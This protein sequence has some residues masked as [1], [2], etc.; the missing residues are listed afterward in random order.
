[1]IF[2][3]DNTTAPQL[4]AAL[5][6]VAD[7]LQAAGVEVEVNKVHV[8]S[9]E[10]ARVCACDLADDPRQRSGHRIGAEAELVRVRGVHRWLRR[11][12]RLPRV[13]V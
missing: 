5:T 12:D 4:D 10:Q 1:M 7:V 3:R 13:G 11:S 8:T 2:H 9:E 6:V